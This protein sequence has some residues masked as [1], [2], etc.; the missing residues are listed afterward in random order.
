MIK[1]GFVESW[2]NSLVRLILICEEKHLV[3]SLP[4]PLALPPCRMFLL[5]STIFCGYLWRKSTR[6]PSKLYSSTNY[7]C[8]CSLRSLRIVCG[9]IRFLQASLVI[10]LLLLFQKWIRLLV[11]LLPFSTS[12][13]RTNHSI[14]L[15]ILFLNMTRFSSVCPFSL[16]HFNGGNLKIFDKYSERHFYLPAVEDCKM[17]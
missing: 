7:F 3:F 9:T 8:S 10:S 11:S 17:S 4:W 14:L 6:S 15:W 16:T 13:S 2:K 5:M 12:V 1:A